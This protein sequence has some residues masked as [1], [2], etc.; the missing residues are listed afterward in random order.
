MR[1]TPSGRGTRAKRGT[2][3]SRLAEVSV[4]GGNRVSKGSN[5]QGTEDEEEGGEDDE[6]DDDDDSIVGEDED[7]ITSAPTKSKGKAMK[8][9]AAKG[10]TRRS[11][12]KK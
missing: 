1:G 8:A 6:E 4:P 3:G 9:A 7:D 12:R 5:E 2:R 11:G 10:S